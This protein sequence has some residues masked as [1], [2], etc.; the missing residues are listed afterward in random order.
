M[1]SID[2]VTVTT[3]AGRAS[4]SVT[5]TRTVIL[6]T[7]VVLA[8]A[9][10]C[11]GERERE[12]EGTRKPARVNDDS[13]GKALADEMQRTASE[14]EPRPLTFSAS[15][16]R[17]ACELGHSN[18]CANLG[19]LTLEAGNRVQ[20]LELLEKACRGGSGTGCEGAARITGEE[21]FFR[22]ARNYHRVHC[23]QGYAR[24]CAQLARLHGEGIGGPRDRGVASA[25]R[26]RACRLG[27]SC[28]E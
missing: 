4:G 16:C 19:R 27:W 6:I 2:T 21:S 7:S 13:R 25:Y 14:C 3:A 15:A 22:Q 26:E 5:V 1:P 24:S 11:A 23:E 12:P 18:S 10:S 17:R 20:G 9:S 28:E 8:L